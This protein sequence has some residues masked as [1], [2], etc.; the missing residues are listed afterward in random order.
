M[1]LEVGEVVRQQQHAGGTGRRGDG[2]IY[3]PLSR[4]AAALRDRGSEPAPFAG[5]DGVDGQ[6]GRR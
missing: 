2:E 4:L 3:G 1:T 5:D 6:A